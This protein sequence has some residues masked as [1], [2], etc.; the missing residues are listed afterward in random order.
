MV[1]LESQ[2]TYVTNRAEMVKKVHEKDQRV[3]KRVGFF[4]RRV[5]RNSIRKAPGKKKIKPVP[6]KPPRSH[7]TPGLKTIIFGIENNSVA[8]GALKYRRSSGYY[9]LKNGQ[10]VGTR[11][12]G[13]TVPELIND[14]GEALRDTIYPS[15]IKKR[16]RLK[17]RSFP[18]TT[19]SDAQEA[20]TEFTAELLEKEKF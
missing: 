19:G 7:M 15:G 3:L 17:Y 13:A 14:G 8:I 10:R 2:F 5:V 9:A 20:T 1:A 18:F 6:G 16:E 12:S 4:G 11:T